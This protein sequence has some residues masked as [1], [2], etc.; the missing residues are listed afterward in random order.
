MFEQDDVSR[1]Q[2]LLEEL[3]AIGEEVLSD[4]LEI[5]SLDRRR[6]TNREALRALRNAAKAQQLV[7]TQH[8]AP[9]STNS[10]QGEVGGGPHRTDSAPIT[11]IAMHSS[12]VWT[13]I[14]DMFIQMPRNDL[15][16]SIDEGELFV[17]WA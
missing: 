10:K 1:L 4:R 7:T 16:E 14:G 13:C 15:M 12:Q 8:N 9:N 2:Q 6:N 17:E 3:E 11:H 5:I